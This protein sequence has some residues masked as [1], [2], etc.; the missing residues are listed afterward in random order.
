M[1]VA[2]EQP[3]CPSCGRM[4]KDIPAVDGKYQCWNCGE[5]L[6]IKVE[7]VYKYLINEK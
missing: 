6:I 1:V 2:Y 3:Y 7:N 4:Q 5:E